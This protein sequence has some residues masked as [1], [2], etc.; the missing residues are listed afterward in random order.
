MQMPILG[1]GTSSVK[2][3]NIFEQAINVGYRHFDTASYYDNEEILG[4]AI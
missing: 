3:A 4:E 2:N 1:L